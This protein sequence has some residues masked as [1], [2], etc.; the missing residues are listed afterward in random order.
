MEFF[1]ELIF[2]NL[3]NKNEEEAIDYF[4]K[5]K[6]ILIDGKYAKLLPAIVLF[7]IYANFLFIS[8]DWLSAGKIPQWVGV[9]WLHGL[10][11]IIGIVLI[12]FNRRKLS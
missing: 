7:F 4:C 6:N 1:S 11:V 10:V 2:D 8:R 12:C 3:L 9:W 5:Y